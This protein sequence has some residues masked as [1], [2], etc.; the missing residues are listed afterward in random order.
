MGLLSSI[1]RNVLGKPVAGDFRDSAEHFVNVLRE[2]GIQRLVVVLGFVGAL[3]SLWTG[4]R[5][6]LG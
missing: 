2:S 3:L 5:L 1:V 4:L 6:L